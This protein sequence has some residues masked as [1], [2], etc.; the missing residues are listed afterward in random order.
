VLTFIYDTLIQTNL[1]TDRLRHYPHPMAPRHLSNEID[2]DAVKTMMA[3]AEANYGL[4][5]STSD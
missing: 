3:V 2:G 4:A 1:T 5:Q